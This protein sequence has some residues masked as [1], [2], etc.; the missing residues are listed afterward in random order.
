VAEAIYADKEQSQA[1]VQALQGLSAPRLTDL[2]LGV[3]LHPDAPRIDMSAVAPKLQVLSTCYYG[4]NVAA[5]SPPACCTTIIL[6]CDNR[7]SE[8]TMDVSGLADAQQLS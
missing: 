7:S 6:A 5:P 2:W 3:H 1:I 8:V 4:S